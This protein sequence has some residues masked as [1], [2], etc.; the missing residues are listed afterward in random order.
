M[1]PGPW[2]RFQCLSTS[3]CLTDTDQR[4]STARCDIEVVV[5]FFLGQFFVVRSRLKLRR[6]T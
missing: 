3:P 6:L 2:N 5:L 4:L 1:S